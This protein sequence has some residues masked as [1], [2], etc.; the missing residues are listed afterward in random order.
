VEAFSETDLKAHFLDLVEEGEMP[1][2]AAERL[3]KTG[4]WFRRRRSAKSVHYDPEFAAA[5]DEIM[6]PDGAHREALVSTARSALVEAAKGG[7]VRAIEK[8][9][10]AY[11]SDFTFLRPA[12]FGGDL[13]VENLMIVMKDLPTEVLQQA[14]DA[15]LAKKQGELP[16]I[17]A[18]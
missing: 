10:M 15:L 18:A 1:D 6:R 9:L 13:N 16:V 7:N 5:Y 17:D 12:Q 14:R 11:D 2:R 4:S 3:G 8:I